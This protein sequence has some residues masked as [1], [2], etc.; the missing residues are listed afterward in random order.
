M[1]SFGS[2]CPPEAFAVKKNEWITT[3]SQIRSSASGRIQTRI[4]KVH[5]FWE[6]SGEPLQGTGI[7]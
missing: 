3:Y 7:G 1:L 2:Q 5:F 4:E 6:F